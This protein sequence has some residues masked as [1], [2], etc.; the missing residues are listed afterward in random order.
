[1]S[2]IICL[3]NLCYV[4][5]R[6]CSSA[7]IQHVRRVHPEVADGTTE[8]EDDDPDHSYFN[9]KLDLPPQRPATPPPLPPRR[10]APHF[11]RNLMSRRGRR[12]TVTAPAVNYYSREDRYVTVVDRRERRN[13]LR[14]EKELEVRVKQLRRLTCARSRSID[15]HRTMGRGGNLSGQSYQLE[16]TDD[17]TEVSGVADVATSSPV[18]DSYHPYL[19]H[20]YFSRQPLPSSDRMQSLWKFGIGSPPGSMGSDMS[21]FQE[22]ETMLL[23][24]PPSSR[25]RGVSRRGRGRGRGGW[26]IANRRSSLGADT[27][28]DIDPID[29]AIRDLDLLAESELLL[30][31][32]GDY[33]ILQD[34]LG[35]NCIS[36]AQSTPVSMSLRHVTSPMKSPGVVP[37]GMTREPTRSSMASDGGLNDSLSLDEASAAGPSDLDDIELCDDDYRLFDPR[38]GGAAGGSQDQ[39]QASTSGVPY[40]TAAS[41]SWKNGVESDHADRHSEYRLFDPRGGGAAS[42]SQDQQQATTGSVPYNTAASR[43]WKNGVESVDNLVTEND[44]REEDSCR[45]Q[46]SSGDAGN[47][48]LS[49]DEFDDDTR[50][51]ASEPECTSFETEADHT[52]IPPDND[53]DDID[54]GTE[55]R[56]DE[57]N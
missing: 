11:T 14:M 7:V 54:V 37:S 32:A 42:T 31:P 49:A 38:G 4:V 12:K 16:A 46:Q 48:S 27:G 39:P 2:S 15:E 5:D 52:S 33:S 6:V 30:R 20:S 24:L 19:D 36:T 47:T 34:I 18:R 13:Q 41:R 26:S 8:T 22:C 45:Q 43:S 9:S 57:D 1:M 40:N 50:S 17:G 53:D 51:A 44:S 29:P 56:S 21:A 35:P 28:E 10:P 55:A 23:G 25:G 3:S